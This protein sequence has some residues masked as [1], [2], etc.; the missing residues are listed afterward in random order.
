MLHTTLLVQIKKKSH[1]GNFQGF[2]TK[3]H[4]LLSLQ[5]ALH[6]TTHLTENTL[7]G[8]QKTLLWYFMVWTLTE[9][10]VEKSI[11]HHKNN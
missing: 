11:L 4:C 9:E 6:S 1:S 8:L 7:I 5:D 3:G 2:Y 10:A